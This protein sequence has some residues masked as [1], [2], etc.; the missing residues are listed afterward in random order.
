MGL[1]RGE[2]QRAPVRPGRPADSTQRPR[3][4]A[5]AGGTLLAQELARTLILPALKVGST[6]DPL[7]RDAERFAGACCASQAGGGSPCAE[8]Q[9]NRK[10]LSVQ[11]KTRGPGYPA[12]DGMAHGL[13]L[14]Q[15]RPLG[16]EPG[17]PGR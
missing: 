10:E 1:A 15:G 3:A 14:G 2:R 6:N 5:R 13:A 11:R 12:D 16:S 17:H 8:C 9:Q 4:P 7:E